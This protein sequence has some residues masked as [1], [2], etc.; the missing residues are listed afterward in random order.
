MNEKD[1][2]AAK[3]VRDRSSAT[4]SHGSDEAPYKASAMQTPYMVMSVKA[5]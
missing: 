2:I 1:T 3:D 4:E 5:N